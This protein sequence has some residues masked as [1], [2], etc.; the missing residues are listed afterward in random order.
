M[1]L[2]PEDSRTIVFNRGTWKGLK[3]LIPAGGQ[4]LPMSTAGARL[5]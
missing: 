3:T 4:D 2:T 5:L 1:T